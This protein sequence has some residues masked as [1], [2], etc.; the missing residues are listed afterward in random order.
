MAKQAEGARPGYDG[1]G[2][3]IHRS[4]PLPKESDAG[5]PGEA[6]DSRGVKITRTDLNNTDLGEGK[7]KSVN[8]KSGPLPRGAW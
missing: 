5:S 6:W 3:P 2:I 1:C 4:G 7:R 8:D